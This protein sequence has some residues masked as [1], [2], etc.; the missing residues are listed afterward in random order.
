MMRR[1]LRRLLF[2]LYLL[3]V[4]LALLEACVRLWGYSERHLCDAIYQPFDAAR[5]EI[6]YVHKPDLHGARA[7][8]LALINT[9]SLGLRS[10]LTGERYGPQLDQEFRIALVGDSVT[11]GEGVARTEETFA[12]VLEEKLNAEQTA[13]RVKVFNFAASAYSVRVM[14][15]TLRRRML[16][17]QP[18]L[19][20]MCIVP[21][22]FNLSRTPSVDA[23]GQLS[24]NKLSGFLSRDS[25]LRPPLRKL[26][27]LYLLRDLIAPRLETSQR[28]E[29]ILQEGGVPGSYSYLK[30]F[31]ESAEQRG[32]A[33]RII[34]LPSLQ[35][36]FGNVPALLAQDGIRFLDLS[37]LRARFNV[38]QFK[39]SKFD[40]HPSALVHQSIGNALAAYILDNRLIMAGP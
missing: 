27:L 35:S 23:W 13:R 25:A 24:D 8:G 2:A 28:A 19:V 5:D 38:D 36:T 11:F 22:D 12:Q 7:R 20:L 32:A 21:A 30:A 1:L 4:T 18:D 9:D 29:G 39:A 34:L 15:A 3:V 33:Y 40:T 26:H 31:K 6:P 14:E 37:S 10:K 17:V 16:E